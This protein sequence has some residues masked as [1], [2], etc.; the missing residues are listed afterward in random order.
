MIVSKDHFERKIEKIKAMI[1]DEES[2][3]KVIKYNV[4]TKK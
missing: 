4:D 2:P 3:L 1:F